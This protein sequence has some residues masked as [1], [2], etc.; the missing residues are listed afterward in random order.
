MRTCFTSLEEAAVLFSIYTQAHIAHN[1]KL[2]THYHMSVCSRV[3]PRDRLAITQSILLSSSKLQDANDMII[4]THITYAVCM[5][6]DSVQPHTRGGVHTRD[7]VWCV[8]SPVERTTGRVPAT[9]KR[10]WSTAMTPYHNIFD[11]F[12][13]LNVYTVYTIH[14][15][16]L[17]WQTLLYSIIN[18]HILPRKILP[19]YKKCSKNRK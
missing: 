2:Q 10:I 19:R 15:P 18:N 8:L 16:G 9:A 5:Y 14:T 7:M 3:R 4:C 11:N 12:P 6:T 17:V 1:N 13:W